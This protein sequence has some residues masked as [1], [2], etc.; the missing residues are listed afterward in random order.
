MQKTRRDW[1]KAAALAA[2]G[3]V[4]PSALAPVARAV[5][6]KLATAPAAAGG[7]ALP[8]QISL[9]EWSFHKALLQEKSMDHLDFAKAAKTEF[10]IDAVEYVNQMF[11]DKGADPKYIAEMKKRADD[12]GVRSVLIMCDREGDLG[13]PDA[14]KRDKAVANHHKWADAAKFL[15]CHSIRV[16]AKS[17]GGYDEQVKLAADGLAKLSAYGE[18]LGLNVIVENHGG[19]SSNGAWLAAVMK[20]VG[21]PNCGTLPDFGNFKVSPTEEYDRYKG[22]AELMPFA[23]GVSAK[24]FGFDAQGNETQID[25]ARM[26][27]IVVDAGYHGRV[28]IE[29]EG[30]TLSERDGI[31]KTLALLHR[32][33]DQLAAA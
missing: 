29:Y 30:T 24:T 10:G 28:G 17:A 9:A 7:K 19:L 26:M 6:P 11:M 13:D 4:A 18:T 16:N 21:K 5:T 27:K 33:R 20:T 15:G 23:K 22:V 14:K 1:L 2:A 32:V 8:F 25:Y 31:K 3:I 12:H